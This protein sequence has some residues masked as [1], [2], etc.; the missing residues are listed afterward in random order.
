M[1]T[2]QRL[3]I[4]INPA[5]GK[6]EPVLSILNDVFRP[7]GIVWEVALTQEPGDGVTAAREAAGQGY[8]L[9]G[10]YGGDGTVAEVVSG[11]AD[12]GP[13]LLLLPGGTGN[14]LADD[15]GIPTTLAEA[16]ALA[17]GDA[18]DV[19]S[20]DLG[21]SGERFFALRMTMG[22]ETAL[23]GATTR[24]M[25][26]RFGW[27]AYVM[28]GLQALSDPQTAKYK[29]T[30]D[31]VTHEVEG[32]AAMVANSVSVGH[33]V[34]VKIAQNVSV[35]DGLLDVVVVESAALSSLLGTAAAA[36]QGQEPDTMN[37]W[38]GKHIHVEAT[39]RQAVLADGEEAGFTPVDVTVLQRAVQVL[40][41]K[42]VSPREAE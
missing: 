41:P 17:V 10:V 18:A 2:Y 12:G 27:L 16:A 8:D 23:V 11:L 6:S 25:K 33:E 37:R 7:A 3:K 31:G 42:D 20:I 38:S 22:I 5:A 21:R 15:L 19:K 13:P 39:P 35:S 29:I 28:A 30:V 36:A 24:E 32:V 14:A 1:A 40:V 4:I 26:D 34:G 9:V